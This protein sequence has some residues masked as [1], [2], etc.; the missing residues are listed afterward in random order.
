[1]TTTNDLPRFRFPLRGDGNAFAVMGRFRAAARKAKWPPAAIAA[2]CEEAMAGDYQNLLRTLCK[3][4]DG[5]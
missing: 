2:V 5:R 1:M 3:Y 4:A